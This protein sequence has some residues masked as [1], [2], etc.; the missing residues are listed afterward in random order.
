MVFFGMAERKKPGNRSRSQGSKSSR[1]PKSKPNG[2]REDRVLG[3]APSS[4]DIRKLQLLEPSDEA[5]AHEP[6]SVD[7]MGRDKRRPVVGHSY[8]P[9][10]R[11]QLMFFVAVGI[12]LVVV[13]GGWLSLVALFDK[14]P[15]HF[16]DRAPWSKTVTSAQLAA[17]QNAK[18]PPPSSP[19]GEP[20]D[21]YPIP[22]ES[23]CAPPNK[24]N[25]FQGSSDK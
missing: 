3:A 15:T 25:G 21:V 16:T 23:P 18:P 10:A 8:G 11:T 9:S 5:K 1:S 12:V 17:E 4:P 7:A 20:T 2:G 13:V 6:S 19:C 22:P 24:A 14:P